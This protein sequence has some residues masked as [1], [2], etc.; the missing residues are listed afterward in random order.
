MQPH[1]IADTARPAQLCV[2]NG[3]ARNTPSVAMTVAVSMCTAPTPREAGAWTAGA[4]WVSTALG[5]TQPGLWAPFLSL[6]PGTQGFCC[7]TPAFSSP[8][9]SRQ[10]GTPACLLEQP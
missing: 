5:L 1:V 2:C 8:L 9:E 6:T 4:T 10:E 7:Q 3:M